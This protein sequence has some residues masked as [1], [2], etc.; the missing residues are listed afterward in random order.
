M[1]KRRNLLDNLLLTVVACM[2]LFILILCVYCGI[3]TQAF[4]Y[5]IV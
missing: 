2:L 5:I 1:S 4:F 3:Y